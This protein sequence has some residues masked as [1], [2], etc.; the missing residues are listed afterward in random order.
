MP[1]Q[2]CLRVTLEAAGGNGVGEG[3]ERR[4]FAARFIQPLQQQRVLVIQHRTQPFRLT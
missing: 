2:P 3:E 4:L 1:I